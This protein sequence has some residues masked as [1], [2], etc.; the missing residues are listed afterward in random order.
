MKPATPLPW[1]VHHAIPSWVG[2]LN[3][4]KVAS[5]EASKTAPEDCAVNAA[6]AVHACNLF[7]ELVD[8][9]STLVNLYDREWSA[10]DGS[11]GSR[12]CAHARELLRRAEA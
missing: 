5:F 12:A 11:I 6:Y 1:R 3:L 8:A 10:P 7:P 9:L 4:E 2:T